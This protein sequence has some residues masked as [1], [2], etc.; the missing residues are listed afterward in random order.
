M[1]ERVIVDFIA[2]VEEY[3]RQIDDAIE[4]T[5]ELEKAAVKGGRKAE[6]A[7][8]NAARKRAVSIQKEKR[9]LVQIRKNSKLAFDAK[10]IDAY[11]RKIAESERRL[12]S[13]EGVGKKAGKGL[14]GTFKGVG[15]AIVAAFSVGV[16][17]NFLNTATKLAAEF[18]ALRIAFNFIEGGEVEGAETFQFIIDLSEELGLELTSTA[19]A[20]KLFAGA[21]RI[22]GISAKETKEIF[23]NVSLAVTALGLGAQ[24]ASSV[25]RAL[26]QIISKGTVSSEELRQQMAEV[27][28]GSFKI[29]ADSME[30]T[31]TQFNKLLAS[32]QLL[33][34]DF[35]PK[36]SKQL[37][38]VFKE[39][40]VEGAKSLNAE[41]NRLSNEVTEITLQL[42]NKLA[43]AWLNIKKVGLGALKVLV[44]LSTRNIGDSAEKAAKSW[45]KASGALKHFDDVLEPMLVRYDELIDIQDNLTEGTKLSTEEQTELD[46]II[47]TIAADIPSAITEF[48]KYGAAMTLGTDKARGFREELVKL[49]EVKNASAL[50]STRRSINLIGQEIALLVADLKRFN[51]DDEL[52]ETINIQTGQFGDTFRER[53]LTPTDIAKKQADLL[54][55]QNQ[56]DGFLLLLKELRGEPLFD[57]KKTEEAIKTATDDLKNATKTERQPTDPSEFVANEGLLVSIEELI[58]IKQ[59]E[60]EIGDKASKIN[61]ANIEKEIDARDKSSAAL[62]KQ[63]EEATKL[64]KGDREILFKIKIT[65]L[66]AELG[67]VGARDVL[68]DELFDA[69]QAE[70]AFITKTLGSSQKAQALKEKAFEDYVKRVKELLDELGFKDTEIVEESVETWLESNEAILKATSNLLNSIAGLYAQQTAHELN[71][72]DAREKAQNEAFTRE[73]ENLEDLK[74]KRRLT[75]DDYIKQTKRLEKEQLASE[76]RI[77]K[78]RAKIKNR[79]AIIDKAVAAFQIVIN[80][81]AAV[82]EALPIIPLAALAAALGA[83]ELATVLST[84][85][86]Q[87]ATG[88]MSTPSDGMAMVG[89]RGKELVYMPE[90][91]KVLPNNRTRRYSEAIDAMYNNNF[92]NYITQNYV[93]PELLKQA[94]A[95]EHQR[96]E[97][98]T[99]NS[100]TTAPQGLGFYD[101]LELNQ[102]GAKV[103]N[104]NE[105]AQAIAEAMKSGATWQ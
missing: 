42:G 64:T 103:S 104:V 23:E 45:R 52:F 86:P 32:G 53:V 21:A 80:T 73:F 105:L 60:F 62:R 43:P 2:D 33:A 6:D 97:I 18:D 78:E 17:I 102:R 96:T 85:I 25:F 59:R 11:N 69:F 71:A 94:K 22:S 39:G 8:L 81:A 51:D 91:S 76:T 65:N 4:T 38:K 100:T 10:S 24:K 67:A 93:A 99:N 30:L 14:K 101:R 5:E 58:E 44:D 68:Q 46:N 92:D 29:A 49:N 82:T 90:G 70:E 35:L 3:Q 19:E 41:L 84:P 36:F 26:S 20:Y 28:P 74:D 77:A 88:T 61:I 83:I 47:N 9:L 34:R 66:K 55:L 7:Y 12:K 27:L 37:N 89:E 16:I 75:D 63:F 79:Q 13:L 87:Y 48:D 1:A 98:I 57:D 95:V 40:A 50:K 54:K 56:M 15:T 31:E 72:L